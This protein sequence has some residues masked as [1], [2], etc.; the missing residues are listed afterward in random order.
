M[1]KLLLLLALIIITLGLGITASAAIEFHTTID[2]VTVPQGYE[3]EVTV[4]VRIDKLPVGLELS[5]YAWEFYFDSNVL[6]FVKSTDAADFA[7]E[8][9][10]NTDDCII[11]KYDKVDGSQGKFRFAWTTTGD[12][13][14]STGVMLNL[15]FYINPGMAPGVYNIVADPFGDIRSGT[16]TVIY[17]DELYTFINTYMSFGAIIIEGE[18]SMENNDY[19]L[20]S[21]NAKYISYVAENNYYATDDGGYTDINYSN[22]SNG[23]SG[24][25]S[26][27][28]SD[29]TL[30]VITASDYVSPHKNEYTNDVDT[31][32]ETFDAGTMISLRDS[33]VIFDTIKS[34]GGYLVCALYKGD[35]LVGYDILWTEADKKV[36]TNIYYS[37]TPDVAVSVILNPDGTFDCYGKYSIYQ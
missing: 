2:T 18:G 17:T 16:N 8:L 19:S 26:N 27:G 28:L 37:E 25:G 32:A 29:P 6:S 35:K 1:K 36:S 24:N 3:G 5:C 34:R 23:S 11:G 10:A 15:K 4:P 33:Y 22:A 30:G 9:I 14:T 7:G 12:Y 20:V 13:I 21:S 31:I